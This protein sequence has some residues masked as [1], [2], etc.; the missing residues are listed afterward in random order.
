MRPDEEPIARVERMAAEGLISPEQAAALR[1]SLAPGG[2]STGGVAAPARRGGQIWSWAIAGLALSLL[3]A[4]LIAGLS[5]GPEGAAIQDVTQSLNQ[6]EEHGTMNKSLSTFLGLA[7][8]L[9]VPLLLL[10][11]FYNSLISKEEAVFQAWAQT[12]SNFQRRADLIPALVETVTAY[13]KHERE[14]LGEVT[15]ARDTAAEALGNA[16]G[17]LIEAQ[18]AASGQPGGAALEADAQMQALYGAQSRIGLSMAKVMAVAEAYP[19]LRSA[20]QFLELQAQ[21]EGTENRINVAR[22]R[23]N[24]TVGQFNTAI[25]RLPGSLVAGLG[26]F[27]RKAYF[28]SEEEAKNAPALDF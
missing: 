3:L 9:L 23:F 28:R 26:N 21:I 22:L 18:K 15:E 17:A 12:E 27:K 11:W 19:D 14:T 24:E 5:S 10:V 25:R 16:V 7:L 4:L 13:L 20:D 8:F 2:S 1:D 6:P